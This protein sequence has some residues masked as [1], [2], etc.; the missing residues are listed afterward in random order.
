M[1]RDLFG[2][3]GSLYAEMDCRLLS[4]GARGALWTLM[5]FEYCTLSDET[6]LM[7]LGDQWKDLCS[8]IERRGIGRLEEVDAG[9]S[10][11]CYRFVHFAGAAEKRRRM[12][13]QRKRVA[14]AE[15]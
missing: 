10:E 15:R 6:C 1:S 8:E 5:A 13:C 9:R 2:S 3:L 4:I 12:D 11:R 7:L 14:R